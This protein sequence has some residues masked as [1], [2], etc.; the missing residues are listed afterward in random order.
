[1]FYTLKTNE[2]KQKG[3]DNEKK[4]RSILNNHLTC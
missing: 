3:H 4:I 1:M 2:K